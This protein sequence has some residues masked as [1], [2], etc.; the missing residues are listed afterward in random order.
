MRYLQKIMAALLLLVLTGAPALSPAAAQG[1]PPP[2]VRV[3]PASPGSWYAGALPP[4]YDPTKPVLVFVHGKGGSAAS[5]WGETVYHGPND[6]YA[7]AYDAGYRTAFVDLYPEGDMWVNGHLLA[8]V[9]PEITTYYA[10]DRVVV[11]AHSKGGVDTNAAATFYGAAPLIDRVITLGSPHH[12]TPVA[13][14]AY[15][16]WTWWLAALLGQQTD[17]TYVMQTGYM[18]WFRAVA[19]S[20]P[21]PVP[22]HTVGGR[23]CGPFLTALWWSCLYLAGEDD[24]L[25]PLASARKPGG[26]V[27]VESRWDHD[28]IRMGSRTWAPIAGLL[29]GELAT[30]DPAAASRGVDAPGHLLLRGGEVNGVAEGEPFP[31]ERGVRGATVTFLASSPEF[32]ATLISPDGVTHAVPITGQADE[33]LPGAWA[34]SVELKLPAPGQWRLQL[35]A[36]ERAGY[37]MVASLESDLK[38]ILQPGSAVASPGESLPVAVQL[39]QQPSTLRITINGEPANGPRGAV[40]LP[41]EQGVQNLSVT[42]TGTLPDGSAFERSLVSSVMAAPDAPPGESSP[43]PAPPWSR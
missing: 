31:L 14:L 21:D 11:I 18:A 15:S 40:Q 3:G 29:A 39:S 28:E 10:V 8:Q 34:G 33:F 27:L 24:G 32:K 23:R 22:F 20:E 5:W 1:S 12:G 4:Q 2:P 19:D 13:D 7:Y 25:V 43:E 42:V 6:M 9:L 30:T 37:L 38:A 41:R 35:S 17:A 36:P 26:R 16:A